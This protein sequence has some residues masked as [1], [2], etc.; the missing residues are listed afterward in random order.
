MRETFQT[1]Y[2]KLFMVSFPG[3]TMRFYLFREMKIRSFISRPT[4]SFPHIGNCVK[5]V[6]F[7]YLINY[8]HLFPPMEFSSETSEISFPLTPMT[9]QPYPFPTSACSGEHKLDTSIVVASIFLSFIFY[10]FIFLR[11]VNNIPGP[12]R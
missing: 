7:H 9:L 6:S 3:N 10:K 2:S 12:Q 8:S 5:L 1:D 4:F 11:Q